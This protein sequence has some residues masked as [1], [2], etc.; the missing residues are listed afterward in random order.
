MDKT[1]ILYHHLGL[2]DHIACH[3]IVRNYCHSFKN[4]I[5][6]CKPH[7]YKS[8][9]FMFKDITNLKIIKADDQEAVKFIISN[10]QYIFK[11]V[12]FSNL[13]RHSSEPLDRQFYR[14]ASVDYE[15]KY[16]S[17]DKII[18]NTEAE[19]NLYN[20]FKCEKNN[21]AFYHEDT[22]RSMGI[23]FKTDLQKI[24]ADK[25]LT[26]CI[27]DYCKVIENAKEI[28][29]IDSSFFWLIDSINY[30]NDDQKL[31]LH[32]Y[33]RSKILSKAEIPSPRKNWIILKS[34]ENL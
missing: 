26:D 27:F 28:H 34:N 21:Y 15:E 13:D 11:P 16:S 3:G 32:R 2:G 8:V 6:F 29:V 23:S 17:F 31:Y 24:K 7:N 1:I 33:A 12:G 14:L 4:V 30:Q 25:S 22:D 20:F 9:S 5:I 18:R 19:N 10:P